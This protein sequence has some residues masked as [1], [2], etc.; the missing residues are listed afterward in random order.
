[1]IQGSTD[2]YKGVKGAIKGEFNLD[3]YF[4]EKTI[5]TLFTALLAGPAALNETIGLLS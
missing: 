4:K 3:Q 2:I 5:G 1:M